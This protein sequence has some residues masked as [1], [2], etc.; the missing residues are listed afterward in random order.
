MVVF[1]LLLF[2]T[3]GYSQ[4]FF[5]TDGDIVTLQAPDSLELVKV[6]V[7]DSR[8]LKVGD[9]VKQGDFLA[10]FANEHHDKIAISAGVSGHITYLNNELFHKYSAIP[11]GTVLMRISREELIV[12][13]QGS[14]ASEDRLSIGMVMKNLVESTGVYSLVTGNSLNWTEG[15]G[16][17]LMI[18]VGILL[19]WLAIAKGFEPLLLIP[20]GMGAILSNIP[21]AYISDEGGI[22]FYVFHVGIE[23]GVFPLLIFMGVG[24]MTDFGPMIANPKTASWRCGTGGDFQHADWSAASF[25][26]CSGHRV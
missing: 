19:I 26:V 1:S 18:S 22:L 16:R 11:A 7:R 13:L 8:N 20:I 10:L 3:V 23:T 15:F 5:Q 25:P 12:D 14:Q 9:A 21:L 24:A 6:P 2:S 4:T 17:V